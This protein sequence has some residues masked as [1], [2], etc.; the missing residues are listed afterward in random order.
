[1]RGDWA[2]CVGESASGWLC[3]GTFPVTRSAEA[4]QRGGGCQ[5][6]VWHPGVG[7]GERRLCHLLGWHPESQELDPR[8]W[9]QLALGGCHPSPPYDPWVG[10]LSPRGL[11]RGWP[12]AVACGEGGPCNDRPFHTPR[13]NKPICKNPEV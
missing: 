9:S 4:W 2:E 7:V 10:G 3:S 12:E 13:K 1:M 11:E 5:A 6:E 8:G